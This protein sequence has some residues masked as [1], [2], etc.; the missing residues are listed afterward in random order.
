MHIDEIR[1][2]LYDM[3]RCNLDPRGARVAFDYDDNLAKFLK[4]WGYNFCVQD[5]AFGVQIVVSDANYTK[6]VATEER[7]D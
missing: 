5:D 7:S 2:L 1:T 6:T 4:Q 3:A